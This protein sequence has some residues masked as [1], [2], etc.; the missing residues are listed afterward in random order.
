MRPPRRSGV[1]PADGLTR[2]P[3]EPLAPEVFALL[4]HLAEEIAAEYLRLLTPEPEGSAGPDRTREM[5][6]E[7]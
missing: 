6:V 1:G 3:E 2:L 7:R 4:D 5:E